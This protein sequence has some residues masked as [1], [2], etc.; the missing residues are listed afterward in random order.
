[1]NILLVDNTEK[2]LAQ[3]Y[4]YLKRIKHCQVTYVNKPLLAI[5]ALKTQKIH[6]LIC[7]E[8]LQKT[9]P[10]SLFKAVLMKFPQIIR[11]CV[12]KDIVAPEISA[13][14]HYV[15]NSSASEQA[16]IK[17]IHTFYKSN[18][19]ITKEVIVKAVSKVKALPSPPKVYMKLNALLKDNNADSEK[20]ANVIK[21]DSALVAKVLQFSNSSFMPNG[22]KLTNITEAITKIGIETLSC[23]V[24]TA[25]MF[26]YQPNIPNF[27]LEEEQ[28]H[29][30]ATARLAASMVD[31]TIKHDALLV[32]LLHNIGKLVLF[33]F[34]PELTKQYLNN[35]ALTSNDIL[36]EQKIFSTD[37]CQIGA[38]LLHTWGFPYHIINAVLHHHNPKKLLNTKIN[39]DEITI[40]QALYI[41]NTILRKKD[42]APEFIKS[43]NLSSALETLNYRAN[44]LR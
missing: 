33:E 18:Q 38:Y 29:S 19:Q 7:T 14:T 16:I 34:N 20:I 28:L 2:S 11:I 42:L 9:N 8:K 23:I 44:Q 40:E 31:E 25:E 4:L 13:L 21:E 27:S 5:K 36:L 41:A 39:N 1:M 10:V 26:T 15:F 32:G 43:L 6:I 30:L 24:M 37:H 12:T 3:L 17:T 22:K 35:D